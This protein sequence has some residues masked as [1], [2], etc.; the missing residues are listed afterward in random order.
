MRKLGLVLLLIATLSGC[1]GQQDPEISKVIGSFHAAFDAKDMT[2]LR[3]MCTRDM[4]WYTLNGKML[5]ASQIADYFTPMMERWETVKTTLSGMEIRRD[6]RLAVVRYQ[7][8]VAITSGGKPS[9]VRSFYTTV[10]V[11]ESGGWKIWQH[12]MTTTY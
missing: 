4:F 8:T 11:K 1:S 12:Q 5:N 7:G 9:Q 10:L 3:A 2:A 6:H